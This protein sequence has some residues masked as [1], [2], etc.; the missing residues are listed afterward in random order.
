MKAHTLTILA[1]SIGLSACSIT[2]DNQELAN[3]TMTMEADSMKSNKMNSMGMKED[4]MKSSKMNSMGMKADTMKSSKMNSMSMKSD[5]I[6]SSKMNSM[7]MKSDTMK[8]SKM[9]SMGMKADTMKS[10]KMNSMGMKAD[11][12]KS[13][14]MNSIGMKSDTMKSSKMKAMTGD[15]SS[16]MSIIDTIEHNINLNMSATNAFTLALQNP[17]RPMKERLKDLDRMPQKVLEFA[18]IKPGMRVLN[19]LSYYGYYSEVLAYRVGKSGEVIAQNTPTYSNTANNLE[20]RLLNEP[21]DNVT[22]YVAKLAEIVIDKPVDAIM[23]MSSYHDF[24]GY[25]EKDKVSRIKILKNLKKSLKARGQIIIS[26]MVEADGEH[27]PKIHRIHKEIV[28]SEFKAA[29]YRL[30]SQSDMLRK[31]ELDNHTTKGY[32]KKR[33]YTDRWLMKLTPAS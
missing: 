8:S 14:K 17:N 12:M 30:V 19:L 23:F 11:T 2:Q 16:T 29:G 20:Q 3:K 27:D 31:P 1:V 18:D 32:D 28:L 5:I 10:S 9:N 26:D 25:L 13:S 6:K 33:F 21:L 22:P 4:I 7:S 24:H 15:K